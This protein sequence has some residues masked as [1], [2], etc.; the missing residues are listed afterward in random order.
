MVKPTQIRYAIKRLRRR[1]PQAIILVSLA[2]RKDN[3]PGEQIPL[4]LPE[5]I[6]V[7][8]SLAETVEKILTLSRRP[9]QSSIAEK[10]HSQETADSSNVHELREL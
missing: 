7:K 9:S 6:I 10:C 3:G 4:A 8:R 1:L 2:E 5:E